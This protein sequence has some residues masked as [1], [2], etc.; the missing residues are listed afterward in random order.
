ML[1]R[2]PYFALVTITGLM[3]GPIAQALAQPGPQGKEKGEKKGGKR[4]TILQWVPRPSG[5]TSAANC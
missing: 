4:G 5:Q 1:R 2:F 3:I